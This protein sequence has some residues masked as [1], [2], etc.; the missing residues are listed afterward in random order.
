MDGPFG[1]ALG[2]WYGIL[3]A[4][5]WCLQLYENVVNNCTPI[6]EAIGHRARQEPLQGQLSQSRSSFR[7]LYEIPMISKQLP[8]PW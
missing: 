1:H 4:R 6:L 3:D 7:V 2:S 5:S 8:H